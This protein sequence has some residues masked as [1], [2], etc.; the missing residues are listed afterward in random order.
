M[1]RFLVVYHIDYIEYVPD[2]FKVDL[3]V[4]GD[5]EWISEGSFIQPYI[6]VS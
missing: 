1:Y 3:Y 4:L 6:Y 5:D 2:D